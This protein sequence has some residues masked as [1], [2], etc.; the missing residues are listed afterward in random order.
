MPNNENNGISSLNGGDGIQNEKF[1]LDDNK[2]EIA[3]RKSGNNIK[4]KKEVIILNNIFSSEK[5]NVGD[6]L[7]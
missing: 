1:I 6:A 2:R 3:S 4:L 5:C 7:L